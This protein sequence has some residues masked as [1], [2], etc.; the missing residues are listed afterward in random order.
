VLT[1]SDVIA[2]VGFDGSVGA[3]LLHPRLTSVVMPVEEI[4]Q[5]VVDR[6]LRQ[7]EN[8]HDSDPGEV[9]ATCL[10][11]GGSTPARG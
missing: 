7:V 9:V 2:V 3:A 6:A 8:G 1:G 5:R 10:R 4:A 11:E